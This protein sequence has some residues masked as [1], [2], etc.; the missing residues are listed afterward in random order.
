AYGATPK[1]DLLYLE[2]ALSIGNGVTP[3]VPILLLGMA[4]WAALWSGLIRVGYSERLWGDLHNWNRFTR[5][6]RQGF[7]TQPWAREIWPRKERLFKAGW[8]TGE[9]LKRAFLRGL[10][11]HPAYL[12][13]IVLIAVAGA[14]L[15][16][17]VVPGVDGSWFSGLAITATWALMMVIACVLSRFL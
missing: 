5:S 17:R 15:L 8:D 11:L 3:L 1:Q 7:D 4:A 9:A 13:C 16:E 12:A 6:L 10:P 2:R 14:R